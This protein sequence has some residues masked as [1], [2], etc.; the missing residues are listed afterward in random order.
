VA[1]VL[2][3]EFDRTDDAAHAILDAG[4]DDYRNPAGM[5]IFLQPLQNFESIHFGH[6]DIKQ[7][8]IDGVRRRHLQGRISAIGIKHVVTKGCDGKPDLLAHG[9]R[10]VDNQN[11]IPL[12]HG[13]PPLPSPVQSHV[14]FDAAILASCCFKCSTLSGLER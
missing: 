1:K 9:R 14:I 8:D 4:N 13:L 10:V 12:Q 7:Y 11:I 3:S 5:R 6:H 2:R